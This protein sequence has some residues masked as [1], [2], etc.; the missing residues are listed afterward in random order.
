MRPLLLSA[1]AVTL[2]LGVSAH[3]PDL[4]D[5]ASPFAGT[6]SG[7]TSQGD[8]VV[9]VVSSDG[10]QV[11]RASTGLVLTCSD[12]RSAFVSD[13]F[14]KLPLSRS[15]RASSRYAN[16]A[17][18]GWD[19]APSTY[20]GALKVSIK[21]GTRALSGSWRQTQIAQSADGT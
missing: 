6:Y 15:G 8:P 20:A 10:R 4:A 14:R 2:M 7:F 17:G 1:F 9:L 11:K 12:G 21:P 5:A 3:S 16:V 13:G 18:A 19:D